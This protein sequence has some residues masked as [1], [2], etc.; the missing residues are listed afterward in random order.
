MEFNLPQSADQLIIYTYHWG[1][2]TQPSESTLEFVVEIEQPLG[3][4]E[5]SKPIGGTVVEVRTGVEGS[6]IDFD[7]VIFSADGK[8]AEA[9]RE[10]FTEGT[11]ILITQDIRHL[12]NLCR[13]ERIPGM[14]N[15][16]AAVAGGSIFLREGVC[17]ASK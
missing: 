16:Y 4:I 2:R 17:R 14:N 8:S 5:Q 13:R 9:M 12:D 10:K 11:R 3:L 1:T 15:L 6:A 7:Q